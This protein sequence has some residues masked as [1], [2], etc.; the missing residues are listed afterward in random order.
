VSVLQKLFVAIIKLSRDLYNRDIP[1]HS[2][3]K[4]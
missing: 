2:R 1:F 4:A 3:T